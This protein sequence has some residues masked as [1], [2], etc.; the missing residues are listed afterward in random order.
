MNNESALT[1]Y[2]KQF[3]E[4]YGQDHFNELFDFIKD[5]D[6]VDFYNKARNDPNDLC[7]FGF[8]YGLITIVAF[9]YC[10]LKLELDIHS[11]TNGYFKQVNSSTIEYHQ[12]KN[13]QMAINTPVIY[14]P[15]A[16]D[17]I[18]FAT[19]DKFTAK[20]VRC[21]NYLIKMIKFSR[22]KFK[23]E[24]AKEKLKYY[25]TIVD[26]YIEAYRLLEV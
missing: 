4:T 5:N 22:Y 21:L 19:I 12:E 11:I 24:T 10:K 26:K 23:K 13:R 3:I 7:Y 8:H 18:I 9:C 16:P 15:S 6:I 14:D 17:G 2:E 25:Y 1:I 20:R